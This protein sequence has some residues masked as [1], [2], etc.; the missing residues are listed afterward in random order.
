MAG[1]AETVYTKFKE[2]FNEEPLIVRSPGRANLIG[3]HT[4]YNLGFVLPCAIDKA[5]Y[6]AVAPREDKVCKL[7]A[8]NMDQTYESRIDVL[9]RS[10]KVWPNYLMGVL[11]QLN[12]AG[13]AYTGFNCVFGGNIPVG[14]GLSSSA[15]LEAGL[16]FMLNHLYDLRMDKLSLVKLAQKAENEFVGVQCGIM[17]QFINIFAESGTALRLDCRSLEYRYFPF[18]FDNVS[19]LLFNSNVPHSL[20]SS[21]YNQRRKECA[22]GVARI[23]Q[24][25]MHV[26]SL[27]DVSADML[28]GFKSFLD[29]TVYRRCKFVIEENNRLLRACTALEKEDLRSFGRAMVETHDGLSREYEVSCAELDYLVGLVRDDPRVYGA[30]MMGGGFGGCTIN[31]VEPEAI[32]AVGRMVGEKYRQKFGIETSIYVTSISSGT[33]ILDVNENAKV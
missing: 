8:L 6:F 13:Y 27:R 19:I 2:L 26:K 15:A 12:K 28:N 23:A 22:D 24:D 16:V 29:P 33:S 7:Y 4:D 11:D 1:F 17:D 20:A 18:D 10:E 30:R 5:I 3:E 25:E 9:Q 31:L 21:Q 14:A 32:D